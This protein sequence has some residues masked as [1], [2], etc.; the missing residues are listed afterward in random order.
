[1]HER[2][3]LCF[4]VRQAPAPLVTVTVKCACGRKVS[5]I[6]VRE[7]QEVE[8]PRCDTACMRLQR[9]NRLADAFGV[10]DPSQHVPWVDRQRWGLY[11]RAI[12]T[13]CVTTIWSGV[14]HA[15]LPSI[16]EWL[17]SVMS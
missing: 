6:P 1:M 12:L 13:C 14:R 7:G 3:L 2:A 4:R 10:D 11:C 15:V 17:H 8:A 5:H 16:D 9:Q